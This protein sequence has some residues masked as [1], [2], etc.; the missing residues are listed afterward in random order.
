MPFQK[1]NKLWMEGVKTRE[2]TRK[3]TEMFL[4]CLA[5][6]GLEEYGNKMEKLANGEKLTQPELDFMDRVEKWAKYIAPELGKYEITGKNG[7]FVNL[8]IKAQDYLDKIKN[9]NIQSMGELSER[10]SSK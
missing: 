5:T 4:T 9:D 8:S 1:G 3:R 10:N 6:G 2:E 7:G